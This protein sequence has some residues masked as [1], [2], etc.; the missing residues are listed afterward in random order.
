VAQEVRKRSGN[1]KKKKHYDAKADNPNRILRPP[2]YLQYLAS[3]AEKRHVQRAG[4][5][6]ENTLLPKPQKQ[7]R[8]KR[9]ASFHHRFPLAN[10]SWKPD[11]T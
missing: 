4:A 8:K 6:E 1:F 9:R 5:M 3:T 11:D 10:L 2:T 7:K